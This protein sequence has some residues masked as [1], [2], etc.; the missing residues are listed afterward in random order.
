[1]SSYHGFRPI[2][3][4]TNKRV[5]PALMHYIQNLHIH[6]AHQLVRMT[7]VPKDSQQV[8][9]VHLL[10]RPE[11]N[12]NVQIRWFLV[13]SAIQLYKKV[14][15]SDRISDR[16]CRSHANIA[17]KNDA[18]LERLQPEEYAVPARS[19]V[20]CVIREVR[21]NEETR[22]VKSTSKSFEKLVL[23]PTSSAEVAVQQVL[24]E[25]TSWTETKISGDHCL[26]SKGDK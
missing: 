16:I 3:Y 8:K 22:E 20:D 11:L 6:V 24:S 18:T 1:M 23:I 26:I 4:T 12:R 5:F 2:R 19:F 15:K 25:E 21:W 17:H 10:T 13:C 14:E 9:F 7:L